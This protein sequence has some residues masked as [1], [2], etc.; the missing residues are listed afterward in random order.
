MS[1]VA[2]QA[3][4]ARAIAEAALDR[5]GWKWSERLSKWLD[6]LLVLEERQA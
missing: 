3:R 2:R 4:A 5:S 1:P 6:A